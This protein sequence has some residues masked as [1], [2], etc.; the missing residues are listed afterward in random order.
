MAEMSSG[1]LRSDARG[2]GGVW[3]GG[4]GGCGGC[5][6]AQAFG[7]EG[8]TGVESLGRQVEVA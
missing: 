5:S 2:G 3:V 6:G 1:S 4:V 8:C 7:V